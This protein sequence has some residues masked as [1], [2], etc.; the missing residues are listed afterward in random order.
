MYYLLNSERL[1]NG[2]RMEAVAGRYALALRAAG[3]YKRTAGT[4]VEK[5]VTADSPP[6]PQTFIKKTGVI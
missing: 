2:C 3:H 6:Y 5:S 4:I 1:F